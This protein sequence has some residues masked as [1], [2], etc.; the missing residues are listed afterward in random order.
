MQSKKIVKIKKKLYVSFSKKNISIYILEN[1][2]TFVYTKV[3]TRIT[4]LKIF[5]L[6]IKNTTRK[7]VE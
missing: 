7:T 5:A 4:T 2:N 6:L 3:Q 1:L